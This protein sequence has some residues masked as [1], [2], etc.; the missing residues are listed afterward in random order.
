MK[1]GVIVGIIISLL[2]IV[3][4]YLIY[5]SIMDKTDFHHKENIIKDHPVV[6]NDDGSGSPSSPMDV[7]IIMT[8][9]SEDKTSKI[10]I[11]AGK[12]EGY[13]TEWFDARNTSIR[14][15][16]PEGLEILNCPRPQCE[17]ANT[18]VD[19]VGDQV[20]ESTLN[21]KAIKDGEWSIEAS[22]LS[23]NFPGYGYVSDTEK[24][25]ILIEDEKVFISDESFTEITPGAKLGMSFSTL[26]TN[27]LR[28]NGSNICVVGIY[29]SG[30]ELRLLADSYYERDSLIY[31]TEPKIWI[32]SQ[33][34]KKWNCF[35]GPPCSFASRIEYP[36]YCNAEVCGIFEYGPSIAHTA[37]FEGDYIIRDASESNGN[38]G[39]PLIP[40]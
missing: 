33:D 1:K 15:S 14:I 7:E 38:G 20:H 29:F 23:L 31:L 34:V 28:L 37:T 30:C 11:K 4:G 2:V 12:R 22:A 27:P 25:Y 17:L 9:F 13:K 19:I 32:G 3:V 24:V 18:V 39:E 5:D 26:I 6:I 35:N 40:G 21:V 16:I 10:T 8:Q 36:E